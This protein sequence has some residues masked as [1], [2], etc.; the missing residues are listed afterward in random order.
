MINDYN[1]SFQALIYCKKIYYEQILI[2]ICEK[3]ADLP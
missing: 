2:K 1:V 3:K